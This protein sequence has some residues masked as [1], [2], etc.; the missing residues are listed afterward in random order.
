MIF[1]LHSPCSTLSFGLQNQIL[2]GV[3]HDYK[4]EKTGK[5]WGEHPIGNSLESG[6]DAHVSLTL[7]EVL[8]AG[9]TL[10]AAVHLCADAGS[11]GSMQR[12]PGSRAGRG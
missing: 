3:G 2:L 6:F 8:R 4:L 10:P 11:I 12:L 5:L 9:E 7:N 1:A